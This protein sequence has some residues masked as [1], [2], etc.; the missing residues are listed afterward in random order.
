MRNDRLGQITDFSRDRL[1]RALTSVQK[2]VNRLRGG[3]DA[4]ERQRLAGLAAAVAAVAAAL[5]LQVVAGWPPATSPF[6]LFHAAV[7]IAA[8]YGGFSAASLA[9]L[10]SLLIARMNAGVDLWTGMFFC[11]EA[12]IIAT[13]LVRTADSLQRQRQRGAA[14]Q[15]YILELKSFER[16]G[17]LIDDAFSRLDALS[18]D[19][20][21]ILLDRDGHIVDWRTGATRLYEC[22]GTETLGKSAATLFDADFTEGAFA[23]L[24]GGARQAIARHVVQHRR[25]DGSRFTADVQITPLSR[26]GFDGFTMIVRDLTRQQAWDTFATSATEAQAQLRQEADVAHRQLETLQYLTDPSV[27]SLDSAAL[28]NTLLSRLKAATSAEGIALIYTGRFRRRV[29]CAAEGLQCLRGSQ[30]PLAEP[31]IDQPDRAL[32]V[33]NDAASVLQLS[34]VQWPEGVS[35]LIS[36]PVVSAGSRQAVIEVV[37]TRRRHSTEWE[38]ALVQVVAARIAGLL[39]DDPYAGADAG[40]A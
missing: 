23:V 30:R 27:N 9:I 20:G 22:D 14:A 2:H 5:L 3:I 38:I 17:R 25:A 11:L 32:I 26:G 8:L 16:Q 39:R 4:A 33:H 1:E 6:W 15:K 36:V 18:L 10:T 31:R 21:V 19:T 34:A 29:F 28:I 13:V 7:A 40:A 37:S 35:S 12:V 24:L